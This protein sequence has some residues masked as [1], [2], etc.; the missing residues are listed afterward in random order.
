MALEDHKVITRIQLFKFED[1][2]GKI[3]TLGSAGRPID[4]I[5][6]EHRQSLVEKIEDEGNVLLID[7]IVFLWKCVI[8]GM[9]FPPFDQQHSHIAVGDSD[10]SPKREHKGLLG[11]NRHYRHVDYGYPL[12]MTDTVVFRATFGRNHANFEWNEFSIA[13]GN[14]PLATHLN[15]GVKRMGKKEPHMSWLFV[16]NITIR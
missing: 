5:L 15:R 13:N 4:S 16:V 1:D 11:R 10:E 14:T 12:L 7:G 6:L 2:N 8:Q 3:E 9:C